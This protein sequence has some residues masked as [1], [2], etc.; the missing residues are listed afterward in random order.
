MQTDSFLKKIEPNLQKADVKINGDR[1]WDIRVYNEDLYPR[2]L[3]EGSLGLGNAYMDGWWECKRLDE[4]FNRVLRV[5]LDE[6]IRSWKSALHFIRAKLVNLQKGARAYRIGKHHYDIGNDLFQCM[7]DNLMIYSC[8]YWANAD[9]VDDAQKAK[10]DMAARKLKLSEGMRLLD[11]GCGW[12]GTARYLSEQYGVHV[13][14]V[15]VSEEQAAYAEEFCKGLPVDIELKDYRDMN[16][17]F[18]AILSIGM[19]EHVGYKNYRPFM[20]QIRDLLKP[21]GLFL[22]HTIG[23][24]QSVIG[25]DQWISKYIFP[26]SMLPSPAQ[27]TSSIEGVFVLEDWHNFGPHYEKTLMAW[28]N[29]FRENWD[30]LKSNYDERFYRMWKYYLLSCAGSFRA[31]KNQV[32]QIVLS[33]R[34][35]SGGYQALR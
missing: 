9:T 21:D 33:P 12:G 7:L 8:G 16:G 18:D 13:T 32:W 34:G 28:Y 30:R 20:K 22:L 6:T 35:V 25:T 23:G 31:R 27:L 3:A 15:T 29:K 11:V 26:N 14:G 4:F 5:G 2:I 10:L 1:P 17:K 19:F 24:N